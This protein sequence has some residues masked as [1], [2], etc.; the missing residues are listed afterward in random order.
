MPASTSFQAVPRSE[1]PEVLHEHQLGRRE[2]VVDLGHGELRA[3]IGDPGLGVGV[4]RG[5]RAISGKVRVVVG[6]VDE[7]GLRC[8]PRSR[9]RL[10]VQR[11]VGVPVGVLG[12]A[13]DGR[14]RTVGDAGAVE[15]R[16]LT[17]DGGHGADLL[18]ADLPPELGPRV[19]GAVVV[20]L[21]G[22]AWPA[23]C[24][25]R[26]GR[27]RSAWRRR[28]AIMENMAAAVSVRPVPSVGTWEAR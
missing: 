15:D 22:D 11:L 7:A 27:R 2:A 28:A 5:L 12:P 18:D 16:E 13:H 9:E 20:V 3:G 23:T 17:G 21:R 14:R 8:R 19:A 26:R 24:A 1:K 6:R 4:G 25:A 10:H